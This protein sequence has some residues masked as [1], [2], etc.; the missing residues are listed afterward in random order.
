[1]KRTRDVLILMLLIAFS[2]NAQT[3]LGKWKT[4]DDETNEPKSIVEIFERGGKIHGRI[5]KLYRK[6][7]EDQD[8]VCD[9][10][11]PEDARYKKKIIGME[12]MKDLVKDDD[13]YS[14]GEI[15]DPNNG[16]VY[17]CKIW[18]EGK[19]LM[20]RGYIGPFYRTQTWVREK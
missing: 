7:N 8:P 12:I 13:E 3:V 1:M 2:A 6:P 20:L 17:R 9:D 19:D 15:L 10:C 11:D 14:G 4:I 16:K 18:L 5:V